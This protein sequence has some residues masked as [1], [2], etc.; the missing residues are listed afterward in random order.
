MQ[1]L[2]TVIGDRLREKGLPPHFFEMGFRNLEEWREHCRK[3]EGRRRHVRRILKEFG[4]LRDYWQAKEEAE[5]KLQAL[6]DKRA[7]EKA[8]REQLKEAPLDALFG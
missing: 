2:S 6:F 3:K 1:K 8:A 4:S 7:A 5:Q